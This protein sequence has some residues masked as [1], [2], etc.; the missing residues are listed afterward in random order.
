MKEWQ[1]G[2]KKVGGQNGINLNQADVAL[3]KGSS[4]AHRQRRK[5]S[6][7]LF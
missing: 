6:T 4:D 7:W 1:Q 5:L 3:M 2:F